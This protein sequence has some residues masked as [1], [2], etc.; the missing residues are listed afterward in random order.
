MLGRSRIGALSLADQFALQLLHAPQ[1]ADVVLPVSPDKG[2]W[3][4]RGDIGT[5]KR[6]FGR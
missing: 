3:M 5:S 1:F 4:M 6:E 2:I